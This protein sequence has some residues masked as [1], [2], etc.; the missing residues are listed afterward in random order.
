MKTK[1][2]TLVFFVFSICFSQ[3]NTNYQTSW[4]GNTFPSD[5]WID[6]TGT[7]SNYRYLKHV[8]NYVEGFYVAPDG[9]VYTNS[10]WDEGEHE[11]G[12]YK[13]GDNT[14]K[15]INTHGWDRLGGSTISGDGTYVYV[16][17]RQGANGGNVG[18]WSTTQW[19]FPP[20]GTTWYYVRRC[21]KDGTA[22]FYD[23]SSAN[24]MIDTQY[25]IK[26]IAVK[27]DNISVSNSKSIKTYN[28]NT[29]TLI[30][31]FNLDRADEMVAASDGSLWI[32]LSKDATNNC[33]IV[34]YTTSGTFQKEITDVSEA[35]A[36]SINNSGQL[37]VCDNGLSQQIRVYNISGTPTLAKTIGQNGGVNSGTA[38]LDAPDKF[39]GLFGAGVDSNNNLYVANSPNYV[40]N[41]GYDGPAFGADIRAF[42]SNSNPTWRVMG[43]EFVHTANVDESNDARDIYTKDSRFSMDYTKSYGKEATYKANTIDRFKYP[44]DFRLTNANVGNVDIR[45]INNK[46]YMYLTGMYGDYIAIYRFDGEVAVP[47]GFISIY[48]DVANMPN[49]VKTGRNND[50][51]IWIDKNANG[52]PDSG[53]Y[54]YATNNLYLTG[55][56]VDK[57]G[58]IWVAGRDARGVEKFPIKSYING[59]PEYSFT[60]KTTTTTPSPM[61]D[62]KRIYYDADTDTMYLTGKTA[63][64]SYDSS[65]YWA[66]VGTVLTQYKNWS[67]TPQLQN[68]INL[69]FDVSQGPPST[70]NIKA[71]TVAGDYIFAQYLYQPKLDV[72]SKSN[73]AYV[74]TLSASPTFI[75][76]GWVDV[77]NGIK[78]YK[79][80]NGEYVI[81][82][83]EDRNAKNILYRWCPSG[84]C[85]ST[86]NNKE[87]ELVLAS[88]IKLYPNP[89]SQ[90]AT[91]SY[92]L[93]ESKSQVKVTILNTVGQEV[94]AI[95]NEKQNVGEQ[96][97]NINTSA[98]QNGIYFVKVAVDGKAQIKKLIVN[99]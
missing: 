66:T 76:S 34:N 93:L 47:A 36:L 26:G 85:S 91:L 88:D 13:N 54:E 21:N 24:V 3:V 81:I 5:K 11:T 8:Q 48:I 77:N 58:T 4:I 43:T 41:K 86:L 70:I 71:F 95:F 90:N 92:N 89:T 96:Q 25:E 53:E 12:I 60:N 32:I 84:N 17:L 55:F 45:N 62:L 67:T 52:N 6:V 61:T 1:I 30:S 75:D 42:D 46:K 14:G 16:A 87:N 33:K 38:G 20:V 74:T 35:T 98:L 44:Y 22:A 82:V 19:P 40:N 10:L 99:N 15:V 39:N 78:A 80:T 65:V 97:I 50:R 28:K 37:M 72:Y 64:N 9:T 51:F 94:A 56:H 31:S 2:S 73:G 23:N 7:S 59:V 49:L 29:R 68:R 27:G 69:P 18:G 57:N 63:D 83:E 79:K